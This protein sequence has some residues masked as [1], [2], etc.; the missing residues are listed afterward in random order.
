MFF[1]PLTLE[2]GALQGAPLTVSICKQVFVYKEE[3]KGDVASR[4][5]QSLIWGPLHLCVGLQML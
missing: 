5:P 1:K 4:V 2:R 3:T